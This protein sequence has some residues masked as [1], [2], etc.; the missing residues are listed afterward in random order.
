M[1]YAGLLKSHGTGWWCRQ[2]WRIPEVKLD[3]AGNL[4]LLFDPQNFIR[5]AGSP[6]KG[7]HYLFYPFVEQMNLD[8]NLKA[9]MQVALYNTCN[10][11]FDVFTR[12]APAD[13]NS[14]YST[15]FVVMQYIAKGTLDIQRL[16]EPVRKLVIDFVNDMEDIVERLLIRLEEPMK[17]DKKE[18]EVRLV[19][20]E[21]AF[22]FIN[23]MLLG[24]MFYMFYGFYSAHISEIPFALFMM[25][26][27]N[28]NMSKLY[29][30]FRAQTQEHIVEAHIQLMS[31]I[32]V[33]IEKRMHVF[34]SK[35]K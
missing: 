27:I 29:N 22:V 12:Y 9:D 20:R 26:I 21:E 25:T 3:S 17:H 31:L 33:D 8:D 15:Y 7:M 11:A 13:L 28:E 6:T 14:A 10:K 24:F 23:F 34:S 5:S 30:M 32:G 18:A 2:V 35:S 1:T 16:P 19:M 4:A